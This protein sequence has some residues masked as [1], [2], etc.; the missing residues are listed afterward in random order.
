M[1]RLRMGSPAL[2]FARDVCRAREILRPRSFR[3]AIFLNVER[4]RKTQA[5]SH[6]ARGTRPHLCRRAAD[7]IEKSDAVS[8]LSLALCARRA[9]DR[10]RSARRGSHYANSWVTT[11]AASQRCGILHRCAR[12]RGRAPRSGQL[13]RAGRR[14]KTEMVGAQGLHVRVDATVVIQFYSFTPSGALFLNNPEAPG[15][16]A[17][18]CPEPICR[19]RESRKLWSPG[20]AGK[21]PSASWA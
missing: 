1:T 5:R 18:C 17:G 8:A 13:L 14:G 7:Q 15:G 12:C 21:A 2:R 4:E 6:A 20:C 19:E 3:G 9:P 11:S 10:D 16:R